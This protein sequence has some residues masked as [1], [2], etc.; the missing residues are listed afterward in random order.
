[1]PEPIR[2]ERPEFDGEVTVTVTLNMR[3]EHSRP[4]RFDGW[5]DRLTPDAIAV[6]IVREALR[7][8]R[9]DPSRLRDSRDV[10]GRVRVLQVEERRR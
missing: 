7:N 3:L 8:D 1:M 6:Q 9:L 2:D 10:E 5:R 4:E